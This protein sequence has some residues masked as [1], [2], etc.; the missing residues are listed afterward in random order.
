MFD[1]DEVIAETQSTK[2]VGLKKK[3]KGKNNFQNRCIAIVL[4]HLKGGV[5]LKSYY[6]YVKVMD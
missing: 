5:C 4:F 1:D 3:R 2:F 6:F